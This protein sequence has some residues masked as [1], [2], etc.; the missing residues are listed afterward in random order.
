MAAYQLPLVRSSALSSL[1]T[2]LAEIANC[3]LCAEHLPLGP[4][5]VLQLHPQA[6]ILIAAQAPGRKVH[7]AGMPFADA[8]GQRLREWLG[9]TPEIFYDPCRI[10]IVPMGFCFPGKGT[11]GDKPPRRE[12]APAWRQ[13]LLPYLRDVQLTLVIGQYAQAWH[14]P[15]ASAS[16]TAAVAAWRDHWPTVVPLPHPSPRN[17]PWLK[18]NP[19]FE[20]DLLPLLRTRVAELVSE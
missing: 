19:W 4:R 7:E 11:S 16:V 8:S 3:T 14:L 20:R 18:R 13:K 17:N 9:V 15:D 12:C 1:P 10:A 5:P 6:R 2:L